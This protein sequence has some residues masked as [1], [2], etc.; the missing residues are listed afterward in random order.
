MD[1]PQ[2][3]TLVL[4]KIECILRTH[5]TPDKNDRA[6]FLLR[7][8]HMDL[9]QIDGYSASIADNLI[10]TAKD[11]YSARKHL[12]FPGGAQALRARMLAD[13]KRI[14]RH[15]RALEELQNNK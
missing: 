10:S 7:G 9:Q 15:A 6:I 4:D 2:Q 14:Q 5:S 8:A 12:N 13:V 11:F 3:I 1:K